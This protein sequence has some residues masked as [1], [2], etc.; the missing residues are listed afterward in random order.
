MPSCCRVPKFL[1]QNES[2]N[3]LILLL[4]LLLVSFVLI[5]PQL[6]LGHAKAYAPTATRFPFLDSTGFRNRAP[7]SAKLTFLKIKVLVS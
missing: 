5:P 2:G 7:A 4:I 6:S 3:A 1:Y